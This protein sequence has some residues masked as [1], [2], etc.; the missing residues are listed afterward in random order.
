[1]KDTLA[2][3]ISQAGDFRALAC[4]T[5]GIVNT[6][7]KRHDLGP[8]ATAA[9]GRALTGAILLAALLKDDQQ[10][11]LIF[12]GNG[13]LK[14]VVA[15]AC[16]AGWCR[17]YVRSPRADVPLKN[18]NIDVA[19]GIGLAGF[20]SVIKD[21]GMQEK[22]TGTV[23]LY[24]SEVA[25]DI[26]Y[27][28][29]ESEQTPSTISLGITLQPDG[30]ISAAGGYLIQTLPPADQDLLDSLEENAMSLQPLTTL[31]NEGHGPMDILE[32]L[33]STIPHKKLSTT[34][35]SFHCLCSRE[36][37]YGVLNS[38]GLEDLD[39]LYSQKNG[40]EINCNTS[41]GRCSEFQGTQQK[42][43]LLLCLLLANGQNLE[44][45]SLQFF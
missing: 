36:K 37:M 39:S 33:F 31:L 19:R 8:T 5:T 1:M 24:D 45:L 34:P 40:V 42:A 44:H 15:Q 20:L 41:M 18:G 9:L 35:L 29:T 10:V 3:S 28:L 26:A 27:Y 30:N 43:K 25:G 16:H 21:I 17:G 11:Q 12:E 14:K 38:L 6:V 22:Y 32:K 23:Q 4:D 7:R 13:P 2:R